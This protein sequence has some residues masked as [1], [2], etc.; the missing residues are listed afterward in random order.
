M[1]IRKDLVFDKHQCHLVGFVNVSELESQMQYLEE[2]RPHLV[3]HPEKKQVC[4]Y[5]IP[6][7]LLLL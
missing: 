2:T 6:V 5:V 4:V 1:Y 7:F 3:S